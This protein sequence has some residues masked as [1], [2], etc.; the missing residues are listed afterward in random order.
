MP[1][2]EAP[3]KGRGSTWGQVGGMVLHSRPV[4][5]RE[6]RG[7]TKGGGEAPQNGILGGCSTKGKEAL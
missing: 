5:A 4:K 3:Q 2:Q 7:S 1:T 6:L